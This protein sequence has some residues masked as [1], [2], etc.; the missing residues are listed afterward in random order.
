MIGGLK[1][2][3]GVAWGAWRDEK[4]APAQAAPA[5]AHGFLP[6][7]VEIQDTPP[8]RFLV[9]LP[10]L[11]FLFILAL[12][13]WSWIGRQD[14]VSVAQGTLVP[15]R[16]TVVVQAASSGVVRRIDVADGKKVS[17][18]D[19]LISLDP[20]ETTVDLAQLESDRN[21]S[22]L[23]AAR[24]SALVAAARAEDGTHPT[25]H[26]LPPEGIGSELAAA[27][28]ERLESEWESLGREEAVARREVVRLEAQHATTAAQI[29]KLEATLP[30]SRD[31]VEVQQQLREKELVARSTLLQLQRGLIESEGELAVLRR[32]LKQNE[33]EIAVAR[34]TLAKVRTDFLTARLAE[35]EGAEREVARTALELDKARQRQSRKTLRAPASGTIQELTVHSIGAVV[36][37]G[38]PLLKIVPTDAPLRAEARVLNKDVGWVSPGQRV[39]VKVEGY[40]F[41]SHG[42]ISG[43]VVSISAE[44]EKGYGEGTSAAAS[45]AG[46]AGAGQAPQPYEARIDLDPDSVAAFE[47]AGRRTLAPGM[48]VTVDIITGER[49]LIEYLLAP[50][51]RY[52]KE[53]LRER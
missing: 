48:A 3:F 24:L 8:T 28:W 10:G 36:R 14:I 6:G 39:E 2:A 53:S 26:F 44:A 32:T 27:A 23:E 19:A 50:V 5:A 22:A 18:G 20:T 37:E 25:A 30:I 31:L 52:R 16:P 7:L 4:K 9:L 35:L 15:S 1:R 29:E 21:A 11:I 12:L 41:V 40:P 46:Q 49:R 34:E 42:T 43:I 17:E 51:L 13:A 33:A 47:A 38:D 45:S